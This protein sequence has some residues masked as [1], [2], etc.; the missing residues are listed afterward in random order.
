M[1]FGFYLLLHSRSWGWVVLRSLASLN[2]ARVTWTATIPLVS[3]VA[4]ITRAA[5]PLLAARLVTRIA[6]IPALFALTALIT[7][8][9]LL[10]RG[11]RR[12]RARDFLWRTLE[13]AKLLAKRLNLALVGGLLAFCFFEEFEEFVQLI[14]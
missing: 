1:R 3:R 8:T 12:T 11:N 14:E 7:L 13:S 5:I 2:I 4:L 6:L 9:C 10:R